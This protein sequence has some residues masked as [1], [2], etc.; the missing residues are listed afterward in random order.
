MYCGKYD[1]G[2]RDIYLAFNM[3]W[4][5]H[6]FD[7]PMNLWNAGWK[8][9]F[10]TS[11]EAVADAAE[12][13]IGRSI[14]LE[15]RSAVLLVAEPVKKQEHKQKKKRKRQLEKVHVTG[16]ETVSVKHQKIQVEKSST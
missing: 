6:E 11:K 15:P 1:N 8:K 2:S 3:H 10:D 9:V 16:V 4:E 12:E 13:V 7:I 5:P 14:R